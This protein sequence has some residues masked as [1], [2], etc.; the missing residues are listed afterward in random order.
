MQCI[1]YE[2]GFENGNQ[3]ETEVVPEEKSKSDGAW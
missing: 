2:C 3:V 1:V